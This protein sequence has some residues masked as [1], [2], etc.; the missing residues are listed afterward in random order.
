MSL[1]NIVLLVLLLLSFIIGGILGLVK[2]IFYTLGLFLGAVA[3][4]Y[5]KP[6]IPVGGWF[7]FGIVVGIWIVISF[8][9]GIIGR[10][11]QKKINKAGISLL[12]RMWGSIVFTVFTAFIISVVLSYV[13][14]LLPDTISIL[15]KSF[16]VDILT[17]A[18]EFVFR[19][20][21]S[22]PNI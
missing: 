7:Q 21:P 2:L 4:L 15:D 14:I 6:M 17:K 10:M 16:I 8:S 9:F 5:F 12:D 1:L 11:I 20:V 3:A 22:P 19:N 18:S 13:K